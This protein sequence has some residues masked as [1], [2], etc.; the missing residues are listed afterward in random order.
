MRILIAEDESVSRRFLEKLL[1]QWG[2][3]VEVVYDGLMAWERLKGTDPPRVVLL[4][5]M[6]PN[7]DGVTVVRRLRNELSR[8]PFY[9]IML[10]VLE[11]SQNIVTA[12]DAGADDYVNKPFNA[13][14]L[15]A[16]VDVGCRM[17][18]LQQALARRV[19]ELSD[20]HEHI[21]TLQGIL[22]ICMH[23]QKIRTDWESW[24]RLEAYVEEHSEVRFS[25][26]LCPDCFRT[27]YP[28][29]YYKT[30]GA[31]RHPAAGDQEFCD[32]LEAAR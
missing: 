7:M 2:H 26:S 12:L 14:E 9:V 18:S 31:S 23:C 21:Q 4:D 28:E 25:H 22:P 20:A 24:Q 15:R 6:M 29:A 10:T 30:E 13:A 27:H 32:C 19:Q 8:I 5:W 11:G 3:E 1:L 17:A 16:R